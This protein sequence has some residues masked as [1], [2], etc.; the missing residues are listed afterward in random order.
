MPGEDYHLNRY[1]AHK[2][3]KTYHRVM[4]GLSAMTIV[5]I[6]VAWIPAIKSYQH[7]KQARK[8]KAQTGLD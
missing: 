4:A 2:K 6:L 1:H 8:H 7:L 5:G 3:W